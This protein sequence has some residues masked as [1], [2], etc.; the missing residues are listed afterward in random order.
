MQQ[1]QRPCCSE[2]CLEP[3]GAPEVPQAV[4]GQARP[5]QAKLGSGKAAQKA[6]ATQAGKLQNSAKGKGPKAA[7]ARF[8]KSRLPWGDPEVGDQCKKDHA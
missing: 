4:P 1:C 5:G 3:L 8:P 7:L 6:K 2:S